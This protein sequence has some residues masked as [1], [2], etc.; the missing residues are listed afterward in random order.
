MVETRYAFIHLPK[1]AGT[2]LR[3]ALVARL[4]DAAVSPHFDAAYMSAE[5][6]DQLAQYRVITS[7]I[8]RDDWVRLPDYPD[9]QILT[10]LREPVDRCLSWYYFAH[11]IPP[12]PGRTLEVRAAQTLPVIKGCR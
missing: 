8:S 11:A 10:A 3:A 12:D 2:S 1:T 9:R 4:G 6:L 7:H 5:A